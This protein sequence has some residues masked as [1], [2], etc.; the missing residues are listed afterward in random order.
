MKLKMLMMLTLLFISSNVIAAQPEVIKSLPE[1][2]AMIDVDR[3]SSTKVL[4]KNTEGDA[5][6]RL[7]IV[8]RNGSTDVSPTKQLFITYFHRGEQQN[9]HTAF[10]LGQYY[11]VKQIVPSK[12]NKHVIK[13]VDYVTVGDE[14]KMV[15]VT[16][17]IDTSKIF[18]D[19]KNLKLEEFDEKH[20]ESSINVSRK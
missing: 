7:V 11:E 17:T 15:P 20:F 10:D 16:L 2:K 3:I 12:K 5:T 6:V 18:A 1:N 14:S 19:D 13:V 9:V 8:D 4:S